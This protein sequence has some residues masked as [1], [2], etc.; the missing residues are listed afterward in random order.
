MGANKLIN[1][2]KL[3]DIASDEKEFE[4]EEIEDEIPEDDG[5]VLNNMSDFQEYSD[6]E[7]QKYALQKQ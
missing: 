2:K 6:F 3:F 5:I 4:D 1:E 7:A